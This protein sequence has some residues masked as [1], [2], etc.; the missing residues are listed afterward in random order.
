MNDG[1]NWI[2]EFHYLKSFIAGACSSVWLERTPDKR[3][4]DGSTPSRPTI[5]IDDWLLKIDYY[6]ESAENF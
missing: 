6:I 5:L 3:E 4:V 2:L 1:L